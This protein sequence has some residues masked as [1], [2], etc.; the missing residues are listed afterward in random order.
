MTPKQEEQRQREQELLEAQSAHEQSNH[1]FKFVR[2]MNEFLTD[3]RE[4]GFHDMA[5]LNEMVAQ[6]I[7]NKALAT[8]DKDFLDF[9]YQIKTHG[10]ANFG[11]TITGQNLITGIGKQI[12]REI[13]N[14]EDRAW[15]LN[16][17]RKVTA[18]EGFQV[19]LGNARNNRGKE[20]F[21]FDATLADITERMNAMGF[22]NE[23]SGIYTHEQQLKNREKQEN[24]ITFGDQKANELV[25]IFQNEG[26][27]GVLREVISKGYTVD[28]NLLSAITQSE[29]PIT[30]LAGNPFFSKTIT[31]LNDQLRNIGKKKRDDFL[32]KYR[33]SPD[34]A[35][36]LK[37]P[38][39]FLR[40]EYDV[41]QRIKGVLVEQYRNIALMEGGRRSFNEFNK[42][43]RDAF[44]DLLRPDYDS[45]DPNSI[46]YILNE[47]TEE[48][49]SIMDN[50]L[51]DPGETEKDV[52]KALMNEFYKAIR[53]G[54]APPGFK[55]DPDVLYFEY[56]KQVNLLKSGATWYDDSPLEEY[57][58]GKVEGLDFGNYDELDADQKNL[59]NK[60]LKKL[61][62]QVINYMKEQQGSK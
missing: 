41:I 46:G 30:P 33:V 20:G 13:E 44:F 18:L 50:H 57:L 58:Q 31:K 43:Q 39:K 60:L 26:K 48:L 38:T 3:A 34:Q 37:I 17:R 2:G 22:T 59:V 19:E 40:L 7:A 54:D 47:A 29:E 28:T 21:D 49:N 25:R 6:Q 56:K 10:S 16:Q 61:Q 52:D 45:Q 42:Q 53:G 12:D 8:K 62:A 14:D 1:A 27:Y 51:T 11:S 32:A 35:L 5:K 23:V 55:F 36:N 9:I 4:Q 24:T 15:T